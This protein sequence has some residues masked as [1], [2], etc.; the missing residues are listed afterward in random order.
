LE[1]K[2]ID[3]IPHFAETMR[4]AAFERMKSMSGIEPLLNDLADWDAKLFGPSMSMITVAGKDLRVFL[5]VHYRSSHFIGK[6]PHVTTRKH[7]EDFFNEYC[8]HW[9]GAVKQALLLCNVV[10]GI[11]LPIALPGFDEFIFSD[12]IRPHRLVDCYAMRIAGAAAALTIA[13]D[14]SGQELAKKLDGCSFLDGENE[15]DF[16]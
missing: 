7:C 4:M 6:I 11:S 8:N 14:V 2:L 13:V 1:N 9:A 5:K 10:C 16:L 15:I 3:S 12:K